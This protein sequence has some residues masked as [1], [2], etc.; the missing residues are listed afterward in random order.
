V[1]GPTG[2]IHQIYSET[3]GFGNKLQQIL[4]VPEDKLET[5]DK[6]RVA[7]ARTSIL[8]LPIALT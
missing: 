7:L 4:F 1:G 6:T 2:E 3:G 5:A 8:L